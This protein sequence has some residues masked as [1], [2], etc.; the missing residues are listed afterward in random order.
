MGSR[1]GRSSN[2]R[3]ELE[4][5]Y[6]PSP[7]LLLGY[8]FSKDT[9]RSICLVS[10]KM[11]H[12]SPK[13]PLISSC[14]PAG[15]EV[16]I[17]NFHPTY[18]SPSSS[19]GPLPSRYRTVSQMQTICPEESAS[20]WRPSASRL[21]ET[22]QGSWGLRDFFTLRLDPPMGGQESQ[23]WSVT[24][25]PDSLTPGRMPSSPLGCVIRAILA[26]HQT[27]AHTRPP[28]PCPAPLSPSAPTHILE[29]VHGEQ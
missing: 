8:S 4:H 19:P 28:L 13:I 20:L 15:G 12:G 6:G 3:D 17:S 14:L 27:L 21:E 1:A 16:G 29:G 10:N 2:N 9:L 25:R 26:G 7:V 23:R 24:W 22:L 5:I 11:S 18:S